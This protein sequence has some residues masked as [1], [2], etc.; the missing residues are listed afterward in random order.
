MNEVTRYEDLLI[1]M[2]CRGSKIMEYFP[3]P[4]RV[5]SSPWYGFSFLMVCA[6]GP[7]FSPVSDLVTFFPIASV[8]AIRPTRNIS[9]PRRLVV[10]GG[11]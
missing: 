7:L 8:P 11:R 9:G 2:F 6:P 4:S 3:C 10:L 1:W 5:T